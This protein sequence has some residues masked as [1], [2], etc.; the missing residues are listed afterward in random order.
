MYFF[1]PKPDDFV[2]VSDQP[3]HDCAMMY[4]C[5]AASVVSSK[6]EQF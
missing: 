2:Q 5:L 3:L 1:L 4:I 6:Q